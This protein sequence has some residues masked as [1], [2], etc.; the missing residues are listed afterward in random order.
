M[1]F[2]R[3]EYHRR[4]SRS[5]NSSDSRLDHEPALDLRAE[6]L[7]GVQKTAKSLITNGPYKFTLLYGMFDTIIVN[8]FVTFGVKYFQQQFGLT[9]SMAGILFGQYFTNGYCLCNPHAIIAWFAV[10]NFCSPL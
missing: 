1:R 7:A 9:A 4:K 8:G 3:A 5:N 6:G 10:R 2:V